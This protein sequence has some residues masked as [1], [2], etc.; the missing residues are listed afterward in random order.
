M[1]RVALGDRVVRLTRRQWERVPAPGLTPIEPW[2]WVDLEELE[3]QVE[4]LPPQLAEV[5][6]LRWQEG[7]SV[8]EISTRL[9]IRIGTVIARLLR[10]HRGLEQM[11]RERLPVH[12][13]AGMAR[14]RG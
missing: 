1:S 3:L 13:Q 9:Q 2:R 10:S 8:A 11:L 5:F 4:T 7:F 14:R 12:V 6:R